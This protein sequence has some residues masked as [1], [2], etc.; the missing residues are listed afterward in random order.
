MT[1]LS[2]STLRRLQQLRQ[3]P[4]VWEGDRRSLSPQ[5]GIGSELDDKLPGE[6]ILWVDGTEGIVR[7]M[8][9]VT[10]DV[11]QE[12]VV[13][14]LLRAMETPHS[15]NPSRP[16]KIVVRQR[17]LQFFLRGVLQD[18]GITVEYAP[19]LPLI[20][21]IFQGLQSVANSRPPQLPPGQEE[22]LL[23]AAQNIWEDAPWEVLDEEKIISIELNYNDVATLYVS[24]LGMLGVEYGLLMYRSAESL[25]AFREQ[26]LCAEEE[27]EQLEGAFLQQDC[28]FLT[29]DRPDDWDEADLLVDGEFALPEMQPSFGNLHPLEGMRPILYEEE[30]IAVRVALEA[31]HRFF[32]QHLKRFTDD[33]FPEISS[34]YRIPNPQEEGSKVTVKVSTMPSF[35]QELFEMTVPDE[36]QT[37]M[38]LGLSSRLRDDLMPDDAY[39]SLGAMS[40]EIL[41]L[42]RNNV[43]HHQATDVEY[44]ATGDGFPIILIQTSRPK[45]LALIEGLQVAGG[46]ESICF[47]PGEDPLAEERYDLGILQTRNGELHLF[48]EFVEDDPVHVQARKKW[49]Q[50]CK[51]TKGHCGLVIAKGIT[52]V[53][54]GNPDVKDMVALYE[55]RSLSPKDLGL[56]ILER[57]Q[58]EL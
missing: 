55:V 43:R 38:E 1:A 22:A 52:G 20:N 18:L 34:R 56:G 19:E 7:A 51:K 37:L 42:L 45:A 33:T 5:M 49:D 44:P 26:V 6:C 47:N 2:Q 4:S 14:A 39:Y 25:K 29:F 16:Q 15:A 58:Y 9:V 30:A 41:S 31:L 54:R 23:A 32:N 21:E 46:L 50:R 24:I 17:E 8:D 36:E 3:L 53:S 13:R 35:A 12:A 27:P 10:P 11:G 48:G 28:F 40:W 57:I